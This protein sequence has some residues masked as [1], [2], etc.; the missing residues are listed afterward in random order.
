VDTGS[1]G[2]A[3]PRSQNE[4]REE[5]EIEAD[6]ADE[7]GQ[8]TQALRYIRPVILGHQKWSP[9]QVGPSLRPDHHVV[10]VGDDKICVGDVNVDAERGQEQTGQAA[11]G[12]EANEAEG[13]EHLGFHR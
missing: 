13:I 9:S 7:R 8:F 11:D 3:Y 6:E 10:E 4:L 5:R 1:S 2:G 12:E